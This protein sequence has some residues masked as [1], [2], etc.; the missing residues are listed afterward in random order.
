MIKDGV[1][2]PSP[3]NAPPVLVP[4]DVVEVSILLYNELRW[5][6]VEQDSFIPPPEKSGTSLSTPEG[7]MMSM[8]WNVLEP[9]TCNRDSRDS[10]PNAPTMYATTRPFATI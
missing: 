10:R 3:W 1:S 9:R 5:P 7:W 8:I 6:A 2:Q 4:K